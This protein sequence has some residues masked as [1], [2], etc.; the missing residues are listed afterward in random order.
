[1]RFGTIVAR[2]WRKRTGAPRRLP[3]PLLAGIGSAAIIVAA[4]L[5][6]AAAQSYFAKT[7][8]LVTKEHPLVI[9]NPLR[10]TDLAFDR[11]IIEPGGRIIVRSTLY[12][13]VNAIEVRDEAAGAEAASGAVAAAARPGAMP[14]GCHIYALGRTAPADGAAAGR[15][16]RNGTDAPP[17]ELSIRTLS[18]ALCITSMGGNGQPGGP[19]T[20]RKPGGSGGNGGNGSTVTVHVGTLAEGARVFFVS[21]VASGGAPGAPGSGAGAAATGTA[22]QPGK[23]GALVTE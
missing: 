9:N 13:R 4:P 17:V 11:I 14:E 5:S 7:T 18:G 19:G 21:A 20:N 22:G 2:I 12:L 1:M 3:A 23:P 6:P 8:V 15:N 16:G 10:P